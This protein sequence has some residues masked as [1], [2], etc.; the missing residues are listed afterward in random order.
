M[1]TSS[2]VYATREIT[3]LAYNK[4]P[5]EYRWWLYTQFLDD[6]EDKIIN[7]P[8]TVQKAIK[9]HAFHQLP[10]K[11]RLHLRQF[12]LVKEVWAS[13]PMNTPITIEEIVSVS[14]FHS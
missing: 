3:P 7:D 11:G 10:E 1:L 12:R 8:V 9:Y 13:R 6:L 4:L 2:I 14:Q 5:D